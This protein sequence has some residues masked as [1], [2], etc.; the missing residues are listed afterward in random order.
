MKENEE[1]KATTVST[2]SASAQ[3]AIA[4]ITGGGE[5]P[6]KVRGLPLVENAELELV[7]FQTGTFVNEKTKKSHSY[8]TVLAKS[9]HSIA[10]KHLL[11]RGNGL[12]INVEDEKAGIEE[13]DARMQKGYI[14]KITKVVPFKTA[15][16]DDICYL[17]AEVPK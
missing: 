10:L 3:A 5:T 11:R 13:L 1:T 12:N 14:V 15:Y 4:A 16:G 2:V 17:F 8:V 9:G 6:R 7:E